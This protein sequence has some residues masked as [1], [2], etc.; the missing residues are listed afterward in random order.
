M[1]GSK[2][3]FWKELMGE[4]FKIDDPIFPPAGTPGTPGE[5][6]GEAGVSPGFK[7]EYVS[8]DGK[9]VPSGGEG[10]APSAPP[11]REPSR[12]EPSR[13]AGTPVS[14]PTGTPAANQTPAA[15]PAGMPVNRPSPAP[16]RQQPV[17]PAPSGASAPV[18]RET[19]A[20]APQSPKPAQP[21]AGGE[22]DLFAALDKSMAA[23]ERRPGP[24]VPEKPVESGERAASPRR[25]DRRPKTGEDKFEVEFDFDAEYP[26]VNEKA[27][28]RGRTKRT[29]CLSGILLFLF[30]ICVSVVLASLGW[31][32]AT[33]VLGFNGEDLL[34]EVTLPK[35]IFHKE[36]REEEDKDGNPVT[37]TRDVADLDAVAD[38]LY[39][40]GLIRY[41][42]LFKLFSK[43]SH[44]D[45]KVQAG[46]W[47]LNQNFDYRAL[48]QGMTARSGPRDTITLVI[49]EGYTISQIV[50]LMDENGVC[51]R[52]ELLNSLANT[53]F[54]YD[55]LKADDVPALGDPKRLEG[56]LFP[57]TYEFYI[58]DDP[59][60]VIRRFLANFQRKW[61]AEFDE[62]A[63]KQGL[64]RRQILNIAA[65][66]EREAGA[67]NERDTIASVIYNRLNH[68]DRRGTNGLLQIDA[69]IYYAIADTGEDFSTEIDS[70]YN[71]YKYPGLPAGPIAN[72]GLASIRA[73]L[74]PA[75]TDYY[76]YA[77]S[78]AGTHRFFTNLDAF[79]NFVYGG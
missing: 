78:K 50:T 23:P 9:P 21:A 24:S 73:A 38:E 36:D 33:D 62:L 6:S 20:P 8:R 57:D 67:D 16:A 72:P 48:I 27:L 47:T 18:R 52:D 29:G 13:P 22:P 4:D 1:T 46:T 3:D 2:D 45:I 34:V 43:V 42:W 17:S 37:V 55:F 5:K 26:D 71:T 66:I 10:P 58:D 63:E 60:A 40:K 35:E 25:R 75:S 14:K 49:P 69:T 76:F 70:P 44:A 59:D 32:W 65:M 7:I 68:P 56:Y 53:D 31:M 28:R 54:D 64:T 11:A 19:P 15:K 39:E 41:K 77:L 74:S 51:E 61:T 30:V 79:N 12:Q